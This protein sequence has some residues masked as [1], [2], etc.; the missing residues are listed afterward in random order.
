MR[1]RYSSRQSKTFA[2]KRRARGITRSI[3]I[4]GIVCV[5]F[6]FVWGIASWSAFTVTSVQISGVDAAETQAFHDTTMEALAGS[7][8]G[9]FPRDNSLIYPRAGVRAALQN[10]YKK[11]QSVDVRRAD[12]HTLIIS[13][14]EKVPSALVCATL[15][16][17]DGNDLKLD[18][19]GSCYFTEAS[20]VLFEQ[21]PSFSGTVY[22]RYYMPELVPTIG[23]PATSTKEFSI[24]QQVYT[25]IKQHAITVDAMLM[26]GAGEYE[27][28]IRNPDMSSSTAVMYFNTISPVTEQVSNFISFWDHTLSEAHTKKQSVEFDYI[29]VRYSPNVYHRFVR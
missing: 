1:S 15:P 10:A 3:T 21:A 27:L 7:Y 4:A 20:G 24:I 18:D 11:V 28:Y 2:A 29:D 5:A 22:N 8:L 17:F 12:R 19:P 6:L 9:M 13:I 26:K 23:A 14:H 25:A 16:D